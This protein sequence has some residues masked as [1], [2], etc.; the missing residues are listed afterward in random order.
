[1][2][3]IHMQGKVLYCIL[4]LRP[5]ISEGKFCIISLQLGLDLVF[6]ASMFH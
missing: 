6:C 3:V 1:M 5:E 4:F 2:K